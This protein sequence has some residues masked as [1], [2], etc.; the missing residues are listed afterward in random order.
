MLSIYD[1]TCSCRETKYY[2]SWKLKGDCGQAD[3]RICVN[4]IWGEQVWDSGI[5]KDCKR[6]NILCETELKKGGKY[7][8]TITCHNVA[9]EEA[10][11]KGE[12]FYTEIEQFQ[13]FWI[14]PD[15]KRKPLTDSKDPHEKRIETD[16]LERLDPPVYF[17]KK[18]KLDELPPQ[19][20]LYASAHGIYKLWINEEEVSDLFAPGYTSYHRRLEYQCYDVTEYL[21][22]GEN[23]LTAIVADGWY[24]G[25]IGAVGY[26]QQ[27]GTENA[28]LFQMEGR[29]KEK[30]V[31]TICSDESVRWTT[32]ALR[33]ADLFVGT[34]Y[35][36]EKEIEGFQQPDF[37]DKNWM[38][39][40]CPSYGYDHLSLQTIPPV[41]ETRSIIPEVFISPAG[42]LILDAGENIVGYVSFELQL[43][44]GEVV[45]LEHSETLDKTGN[46]L[47][48]IIGHNKDQKDFY[49]SKEDGVH[50]FKP[51]F[52]QHGFRYVRVEG[53][54]DRNPDHYRIHVVETPMKVTG[55]FFCSDKKLNKLQENILR[56]QKGNMICIPTDCP[57]REKTGW[58]GDVQVYA[59]TAC[60]EQDVE[61]FLR[62]WLEDMRL[63][64]LE[65]G[66]IPHI[67]PYIPSHDYMKPAGIEGVSAAGW[68]DA[69]ILLPWR[70]YE[71]YGDQKIL[72]ENFDMICRYMESVEALASEI[73]AELEG[74]D[75][76]VKERQKYLWNTGFQYGDWLM[77]SIQMS[78]RSI[79]EV[80]QETGYI[81][82]SLMY[83]ITTEV[84]EK[85]CHV[86][87][88][89]KLEEK[90]RQLHQKI[91][92]AFREEYIRE[93]HTIVKNYQG[94]YVL[95]LQAHILNPIETQTAVQQLVKLIREND[96]RLDTGFLSVNYLLP[97]LAENGESALA[98]ELL[99]QDKCPSWLYEVKMG[100]TTM[101]EYWNGYAED[102][103]PDEGSMN[104][105]AFGCVGEYL[106]RSILGISYKEP[107]FRTIRIAPDFFCGLDFVKGTYD[108]IWGN[109]EIFWKK[110]K[111]L[112]RLDIV[113]PP[114]VEAEI[115]VEDQ[116]YRYKCGKYSIT[117]E[118]GK[119]REK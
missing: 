7:E 106:Y 13:A 25:K 34:Y 19:T 70:L 63:E 8:F 1:A 105:F 26:G 56:S 28:F 11:V 12:A 65:D 20:L 110:E 41:K 10:S 61:G 85:I 99:F 74:E 43:E 3:Y 66:Q 14:E 100:A 40:K 31:F 15:R 42:E 39:V 75:Q 78:G 45:S 4:N 23:V 89:Q 112:V 57:Q 18:F 116:I 2:F 114:D 22:K 107:G 97:V 27:Y 36:A 73:P 17:R 104:H 101:W 87:S 58:T 68:S 16:P 118:I 102:G 71:A 88:E 81:V 72:E 49:R 6:H 60:Y 35:D 59:A 50:F 64:Q 83:A 108:S 67:I 46:F 44:K 95:A 90:Y 91:G 52:T 94:V 29:E 115:M 117:R 32:G 38:K 92:E 103:T 51:P 82:A 48:N 119:E 62:H 55:T 53:T 76:N 24:T 21:R 96:T 30:T 79:F 37:E 33:Y 109:I 111:N 98:N 9:G 69:A 84:M 86:L 80:V 54:R 93:D 5:R 47:K 77:P 113:I